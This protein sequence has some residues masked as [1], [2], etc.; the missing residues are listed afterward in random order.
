MCNNV[1]VQKIRT[2]KLDNKTVKLQ[3]VSIYLILFYTDSCLTNITNNEVLSMT[4]LCLKNEIVLIIQ[5]IKFYNVYYNLES[6][7]K[8][9]CIKILSSSVFKYFLLHQCHV[10]IQDIFYFNIIVKLFMK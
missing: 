8:L 3:I 9:L 6:N 7:Y 4:K 10:Q 1:Y 2:I 5:K